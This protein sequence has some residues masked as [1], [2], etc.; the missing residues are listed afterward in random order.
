MKRREKDRRELFYLIPLFL[1]LHHSLTLLRHSSLTDVA[2]A[3]ETSPTRRGFRHRSITLSGTFPF[4]ELKVTSCR[5]AKRE[6]LSAKIEWRTC[7]SIEVEVQESS[8]RARKG[9][10]LSRE[11]QGR[12]HTQMKI[13][14]KG[15]E[16]H[17]QIKYH[18]RERQGRPH[19][20]Q[21][22]NHKQK[23]SKGARL[24]LMEA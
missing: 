1:A 7:K 19:T 2:G 20:N 21:P 14:G 4:L 17:T 13:Q 23:Q 11:R 10:L 24:A 22:Y 5:L 12:P 9:R 3:S 16:G 15:K 18:P 8:V 6:Y